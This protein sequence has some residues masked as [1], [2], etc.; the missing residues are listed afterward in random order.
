MSKFEHSA[1]AFLNRL[2]S[3]ILRKESIAVTIL[4][5]EFALPRA[6]AA[7]A[8]G[9]LG[10]VLNST[11][12]TVS[13]FAAESDDSLIGN[14]D[15][16]IS[17][18][19]VGSNPEQIA[20]TPDGNY[21]FVSSPGDNTVWKIDVSD[22]AN[23]QASKITTFQSLGTPGGIAVTTYQDTGNTY[24]AVWVADSKNCV[25]HVLTSESN[26]TDTPQ[27]LS[28]PSSVTSPSTAVCGSSIAL[29]QVVATPDQQTAVFASFNQV[30]FKDGGTVT[31]VS[32]PYVYAFDATLSTTNPVPLS[33]NSSVITLFNPQSLN[34]MQDRNGNILLFI[35][36]VGLDT[37]QA[38]YVS[39]ISPTNLTAVGPE[40]VVDDTGIRPTSIETNNLNGFPGINDSR[41]D[42]A[43]YLF[44]GDGGGGLNIYPIDCGSST[45]PS[46]SCTSA[47]QVGVV[48]TLTLKGVATGLAA[49]PSSFTGDGRA[50]IIYV[51]DSD[52]SPLQLVLGEGPGSNFGV[53]CFVGT[54]GCD[55]GG[56]VAGGQVYNTAVPVGNGPMGV[57]FGPIYPSSPA[58]TW[59]T[60]YTTTGAEPYTSLQP[61]PPSLT[62]P[63]PLTIYVDQG[64]PLS[65]INVQALS[66]VSSL[67]SATLSSQITVT[68]DTDNANYGCEAGLTTCAG[69][70]GPET[71][72]TTITVDG[73]S[74][75]LIGLLRPD[76]RSTK[77]SRGSTAS[78]ATGDATTSAGDVTTISFQGTPNSS[79]GCSG[80][81]CSQSSNT[82]LKTKSLCTLQV[83]GGTAALTIIQGTSVAA[84]L[85]CTG[86]VSDT[87]QGTITWGDPSSTDNTSSVDGI[88]QGA[89]SVTIP[90][91][92]FPM[93]SYASAGS[94][95]VG[96]T[97]TDTTDASNNYSVTV[98]N[99][100]PGITVTVIALL[101]FSTTSL[102]N[103]SQG[104]AYGPA[105][106][107]VSGGTAPFSWS[108]SSGSLPSGLSLNASTGQI[109]GTPTAA[110]SFNFTVQVKDSGS[111]AQTATQN[112]NLVINGTA[113][114][115]LEIATTSLPSANQGSAYGPIVVQVTGGTPSYTWSV[116]SG[117][118]PSGLSLNASNGQISGTPTT[119]GT[120]SF[121]VQVMDS[122]S[123]AQTASQVL[124][125]VI[126]PAVLPLS[127][128]TT[129]LTNGTQS[130][131]YGPVTLQATGGTAPYTWSLSSGTLPTGLSL[132]ASN[133]QIS[134]TPSTSGTFSFTVQVMDSGSPAQMAAQNLSIT[135]AQAPVDPTII[136]NST[137]AAVV[138]GQSAT[139]SLGFQGDSSDAGAVFTISCQGLPQGSTCSYSPNPFA[140][141]ASGVGTVVVT[142]S[143]S[144]QSTAAAALPG[145]SRPIRPLA[146]ILSLSG[147]MG[148]LLVCRS[149]KGGKPRGGWLVFTFLLVT[150]LTVASACSTS[151]TS[152]NLACP[153]CTPTGT[154]S[155]QIVATSQN[156]ALQSSVT[157][158]LQVGPTAQ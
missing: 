42:T 107:Q 153:G 11:D 72:S 48:T 64:T 140:L 55:T 58:L 75:D 122:G 68:S 105:T 119:S 141:D 82:S 134:G 147:V 155:I 150:V 96:A 57:T 91:S 6:Y 25:M 103:G 113:G 65:D 18:V 45:S 50:S 126:S 80:S 71:Q 32:A 67:N 53:P 47:L 12:G 1:M 92:S 56:T 28:P 95:T 40:Q 110:G 118:L 127:I 151:V 51:T 17:T 7:Q 20:A 66:M 97:A 154:S 86:V 94:F 27:S 135:I 129:S 23:P 111:P 83:N 158:T 106:V 138:P 16:L 137:S 101:S 114:G 8:P 148:L 44:V 5:L 9:F 131:A 145:N 144:G 62:T 117:A 14:N 69:P 90:A 2:R 74:F 39:G 19:K 115:T 76:R 43:F 10:Y 59:L 38:I 149:K 98:T 133:G 116:S 54:A 87:L 70:T 35:G 102:P 132:N 120:F 49:I 152:T 41:T 60:G 24:Y 34:A 15:H 112:F 130:S 99:S 22:P 104:S 31:A 13:I 156:P 21:A 61:S 26:Y 81:G 52:A 89:T 108:I 4:L 85:T 157:V 128:T 30:E 124:S 121:T 125:I 143:T 78:S 33:F 63:N 123:P 109:S 84:D 100:S 146:P 46:I 139:F 88:A 77:P 136:P 93:H 36:D 29:P 79:N 73:T 3:V 37:G 142:I